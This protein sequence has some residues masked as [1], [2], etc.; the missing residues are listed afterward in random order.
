MEEGREV[1]L[2]EAALVKILIVVMAVMVTSRNQTM[3]DIHA[4]VSENVG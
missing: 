2:M 1:V 4:R 3:M